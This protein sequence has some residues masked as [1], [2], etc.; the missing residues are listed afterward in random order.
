[1]TRSEIIGAF[2][3][4]G[5]IMTRLG[6]NS[7]YE[8][9]AMGLTE[10]EFN[11]LNEIIIREK[12]Y[13]GWFTEE[14]VRS[15]L[16]ALGDQLSQ[17]RLE[18]WV[19]SYTFSMKPKTIALIMAGNI[20]L[21]GFHDFLCVLLSGNKALVKL[22]S[23]DKNLFPALA[24]YLLLFLPALRERIQFAIGPLKEFDAVI[25]T[26]S[27]N[28]LNYFEDYFG[29]YPHLFRKNRTSVAVLDGNETEEELVAL[30]HDIFAYYGLGCRNVSQLLIP[31]DFD[32]SRFFKGI[33]P[34]NE[35]VNNKK[36]GNNYDYHKVIFLMNRESLLDNNFVLLKESDEL[37]SPLSMIYYH[38]YVD[39]KEIKTFLTE[40]KEDIQA[41]VGHGFIPFGGAQSPALDDF[42]DGVDTMRWIE[43]LTA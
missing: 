22:S 8:G 38:R 35:V 29:K 5:R 26:G 2:E 27:N 37:F 3:Q 40:R 16:L 20:P 19:K 34:Y 36:Y 12:H 18:G 11:K 4:L 39:Q 41:V 13:N 14:S 6:E 33:L 15:S 32:L 30:G 9:Y 25:A 17:E 10:A 21:V 28:T 31:K 23:D 42:A 24:E 1:M 43:G 7:G